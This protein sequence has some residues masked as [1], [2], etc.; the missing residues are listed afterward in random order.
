LSTK[1][2]AYCQARARLDLAPLASICS[3]IGWRL[4]R[5]VLEDERPLGQR[6]L[7]V[8]DG[9]MLSM[10]DT[11]AN[12][13]LWPQSKI[14]KPGVGFPALKLV[15]VFSLASGALLD[16]ATGNIHQHES[17]LFCTLWPNL[18]RGDILL[19]DRG[20][21][22]YVALA[23]LRQ[24][25]VDSLMRL[26]GRRKTDFE[27]GAKLGHEDWRVTW[28]KPLK[29]PPHW[30]KSEFE[31]LAATM[32]VRLIRCQI[33]IRGRRP[34]T[35]T[36]VTTL[37]DPVAYPA[38][39]LRALYAQRWMVEGHFFAI[40]QLLAMDILR[41]K[42]PALIKREVLIHVIAYNL[43]RALMQRAAH[44]HH[45]PLARISFKGAVDALRQWSS[46][47]AAAS[48]RPKKQDALIEELLAAL[49]RDALP[50]RPGRNEPRV[51][52]RRPKRYPMMPCPR[53]QM[54]YHPSRHVRR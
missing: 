21:C 7:K 17:T 36:L 1:T 6:T 53:N 34:K 33:A 38:D 29:E 47:I 46:S 42:S 24:R 51:K 11:P 43:V 37:L 49:A 41:C 39:T 25:G 8:V 54:S 45:V 26:A 28:T 44:N 23:G 4:E 16:H 13:A 12:Q 52:K 10:P 14:Q 27:R 9:T 20:F 19:A 3:Q 5:N 30:T 2:S 15:G 22:S 31:V 50:L 35:V 18:S 32:D 40:K 48:D